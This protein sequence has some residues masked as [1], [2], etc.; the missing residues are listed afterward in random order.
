MCNAFLVVTQQHGAL[1][2]RSGWPALGLQS[3]QARGVQHVVSRQVAA[4]ELAVPRERFPPVQDAPVVYEECLQG[5]RRGC[6]DKGE[7][8]S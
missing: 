1:P 7:H 8:R 4:T 5:K 2:P 6:W 3:Q